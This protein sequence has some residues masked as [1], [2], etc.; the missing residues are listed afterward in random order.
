MTVVFSVEF[1]L[2]MGRTRSAEVILEHQAIG[3]TRP[4]PQIDERQPK[5][6]WLIETGNQYFAIAEIA[7]FI[8]MNFE[9]CQR[10]T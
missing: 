9:L 2:A 6:P 3:V 5:G 10:A 1:G 7:H 8:C 4:R